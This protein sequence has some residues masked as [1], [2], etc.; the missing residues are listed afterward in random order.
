MRRSYRR[1]SARWPLKHHSRF[2][3]AATSRKHFGN[4]HATAEAKETFAAL[5]NRLANR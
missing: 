4:V 5:K 2:S 1:L 3:C